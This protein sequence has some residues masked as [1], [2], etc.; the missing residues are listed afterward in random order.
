V[1]E[2]TFDKCD[3]DKM[4]YTK[5]NLEKM[6]AWIRAARDGRLPPEEAELVLLIFTRDENHYWNLEENE[7]LRQLERVFAYAN[8][9][10]PGLPLG[11]S[12]TSSLKRSLGR[13][14]FHFNVENAA[15]RFL[16]EHDDPPQM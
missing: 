1:K 10:Y 11:S 13:D 6:N 3:T 8:D 15:D 12:R 2:R 14:C 7:A 5:K 9:D 4:E 16:R